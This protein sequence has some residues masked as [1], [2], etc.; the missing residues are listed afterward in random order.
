MRWANLLFCCLF[1]VFA[2]AETPAPLLAA[3]LGWS[4]Q[5]GEDDD[6]DASEDDRQYS[7]KEQKERDIAEFCYEQRSIC[8]KICDLHSNF[9]D[10]FDGCSHSCDSRRGRCSR[11]GCYRWSGSEYV[12]AQRFGGNKC[13]L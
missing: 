4:P 5:V 12:Y 13:M 9:D 11:S 2:F 1:L 8:R 6:S 3:D 7:D 10:R